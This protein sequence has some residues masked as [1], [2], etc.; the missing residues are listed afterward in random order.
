MADGETCSFLLFISVKS[1]IVLYEILVYD[2]LLKAAARCH[3]TSTL[4][5]PL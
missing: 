3:T 2:P 4:F 5:L 1:C